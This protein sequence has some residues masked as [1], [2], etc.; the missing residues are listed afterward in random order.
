MRY[1]DCLV[2]PLFPALLLAP[3]VLVSACMPQFA[4]DGATSPTLQEPPRAAAETLPEAAA[5]PG[6]ALVGMTPP[7]TRP[8]VRA[9]LPPLPPQRPAFPRVDAAALAGISAEEALSILGRPRH[10]RSTEG[11]SLWVYEHAACR[12][13]LRFHFSVR[14]NELRALGHDIESGLEKGLHEAICLH[15]LALPETRVAANY[16]G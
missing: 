4:A 16:D 14:D 3:A 10:A 11:V 15:L 12:L 7:P 1:R 5:E 8:V 9:S 13:T 2:R 6:A